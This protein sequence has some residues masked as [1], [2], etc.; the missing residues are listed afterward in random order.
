MR[1]GFHS[2]AALIACLALPLAAPVRAA[3]PVPIAD[4]MIMDVCV[5]AGD[6]ILPRLVPG[7]EACTR[8]RDIRPGETPP[9]ELRNFLNPGHGCTEDGGTVAKLNRPVARDGTIR[10]VSSTLN[11]AVS[12]CAG[13][14]GRPG[15]AGDGGASI[16][17]YDEGYGFIMGSYSPVA[18]SIYQTPLCRDGSTS[19]RRFFRGWVIGPSAVPAVG[20]TG[21]GVF[22]G[23][24]ATG[25]ASQ[26]S[27]TCPTRYRRAL[28]SWLVAP[29][30]YRS[31]RE[32][33]SIVS[34]HFAQVSRDGLSPGETMQ[35]EQTY[36]T[37]EF[38]LSRWEKWARE[39]WVHPRSGRP[40]PDLARELYQRGRCGAPVAGSFD[41]SP[42][43]RFT[44][45]PGHDDA[46]DG[47]YVRAILD[48]QT[49]ARTLWYM[50]LCEDY[51]NIHP[52]AA[53]KAPPDVSP[54]AD[55]AYWNP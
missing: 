42:R 32:L 21:F 34:S 36:W 3:E 11:V 9:Y 24:L 46:R 25:A 35:M 50:T 4:F 30:R 47:A 43:T 7:D 49:G 22:E 29:M 28:T 6:R 16:Q 39:G 17:W 48:P 13:T 41:I 19:S 55:R 8:R 23:R 20:T 40:A 2:G 44:P 53:G 5:D 33:V 27:A 10:I 18:L 14:R 52:L 51:T 38:G 12:G 54:I 31:G 45:A 1:K 37:R 26:L 15:A